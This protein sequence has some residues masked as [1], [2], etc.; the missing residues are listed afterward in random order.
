MSLGLTKH[1]ST[2]SLIAGAVRKVPKALFPHGA[3][4]RLDPVEKMLLSSFSCTQRAR[5]S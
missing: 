2:R 1:D 3:Q 5:L 4:S